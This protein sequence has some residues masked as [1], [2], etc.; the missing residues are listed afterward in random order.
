MS[1]RSDTISEDEFMFDRLSIVQ[2]IAL[3]CTIFAIP[4][5]I[6]RNHLRFLLNIEGV[7]KRF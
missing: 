1:Y 4:S 7:Y 2:N 3:I 5:D 6:Q